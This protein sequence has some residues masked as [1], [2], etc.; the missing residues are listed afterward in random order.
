MDGKDWVRFFDLIDDIKGGAR[1][2]WM[3]R[4]GALLLAVAEE[5]KAAGLDEKGSKDEQ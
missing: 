2:V 4:Y 5:I 1:V 3:D